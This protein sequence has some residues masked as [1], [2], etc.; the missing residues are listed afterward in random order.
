MRIKIRATAVTP[1]DCIARSFNVP[2][3][4]SIPA[5]GLGHHA[6]DRRP[7]TASVPRSDVTLVG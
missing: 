1:S 5:I 2:A 3:S 4:M 6:A 7:V